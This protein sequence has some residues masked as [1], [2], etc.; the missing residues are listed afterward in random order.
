MATSQPPYIPGIVNLVSKKRVND[1]FVQI[2]ISGSC[3]KDLAEHGLDQRIK[4]LVPQ[5][6]PPLSKPLINDSKHWY[7]NWRSLS[8]SDREAMRT[9][10]ILNPSSDSESLELLIANHEPEGVVGKWLSA[11]NL[12]DELVVVFPNKLSPDSFIGI[13]WQPGN[14]SELLLLGDATSIPA[15]I[16]ILQG[17]QSD[18]HGL[19]NGT[20]VIESAVPLH[21][22]NLPETAL[23]VVWLPTCPGDF[24]GIQLASWAASHFAVIGNGFDAAAEDELVWDSP[25]AE[26]RERYLWCAAEAGAV[27]T[28]RRLVK[29]S[30]AYSKR[31]CAFMGY[32]KRG[33]AG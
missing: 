30:A 14:A 8:D 24:P 27:K 31:D 33:F 20:V 3:L 22:L 1:E 2:K 32:W 29:E 12:D 6:Q 9:Y 4:I 5:Q 23:E 17:I 18:G 26:G 11:A 19:V 21:A 28:I 15:I 7:E 10:T 16:G 13:D 25:V